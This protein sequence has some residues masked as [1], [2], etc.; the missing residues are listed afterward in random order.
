MTVTGQNLVPL[1]TYWTSIT[2]TQP[3]PL[4]RWVTTS[5]V[6]L[7][8]CILLERTDYPLSKSRTKLAYLDC[9][10]QSET[11]SSASWLISPNQ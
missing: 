9:F 11:M 5:N 2:G 3:K 8:L 4:A 6:C 1:S 10:K 7:G